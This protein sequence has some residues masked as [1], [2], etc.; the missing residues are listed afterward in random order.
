M[1]NEEKILDSLPWG[2]VQLDQNGRILTFNR[3]A[4]RLTG[5][6]QEAVLGKKY[7]IVLKLPVE[8]KKEEE[9]PGW[10]IQGSQ[11]QALRCRLLPWGD[12]PPEMESGGLLILEELGES[13]DK[14]ERLLEQERLQGV[15]ELGTTVAHKINQA[16]QVVMGYAS[17]MIVDLPPEHKYYEFIS[18]IIQ[19][20]EDVRKITQKI[21][22]ISRYAVNERPDGHRMIDLDLASIS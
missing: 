7:Y 6:S 2:I 18:S 21:S 14:L 10:V 5:L 11:R 12:D 17:L 13:T 1:R 15:Q 3:R 8:L 4:S 19:Q 16:L 20:M 9:S 22:N